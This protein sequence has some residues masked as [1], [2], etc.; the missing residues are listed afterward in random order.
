MN[1]IA[2]ILKLF[3]RPTDDSSEDRNRWRE[4]AAAYEQG[5]ALAAAGQDEDALRCFDAALSCGYDHCGLAFGMRGCCLQALGYD[6]DAIDDF[7]K[8]IAADPHDSNLYYMRSLSKSATG[9]LH[10]CLADLQEAIRVVML[11]PG[12]NK[13]HDAHARE[14]GHTGGIVAV[15][16]QWVLRAQL[17][18]EEQEF[19]ER[20]RR[21][22][23][24]R[25][26]GP[27]LATRR[28]LEARRRTV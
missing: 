9:D 18:L 1:L 26:F 15:Y 23:P 19:D 24:G 21:E 4:G 27:D 17:D 28:R 6:L 5:M 10:G 16:K 12:A 3:G 7:E 13:A 20:R 14:L 2:S 25:P 22:C 11:H 8:A